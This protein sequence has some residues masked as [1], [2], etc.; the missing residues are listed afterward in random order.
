MTVNGCGKLESK[1]WIIGEAPG[2]NEALKGL[3]FVGGAGLVLDSMLEDAKIKRDDCYIDNV[4]QDMPPKNNF[5]V[6][7]IGSTPSSELMQAHMRIKSL[8]EKHKPNVVIALGNEA[9]YALTGE[10]ANSKS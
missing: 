2:A 8:V 5:A 7:Y 1:I 9:L 4:I 6:Y 10:R 3:P